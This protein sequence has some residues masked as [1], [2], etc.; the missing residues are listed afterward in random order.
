M[1]GVPIT[2]A[3]KQLRQRVLPGGGFGIHQDGEFR[4]DATAWGIIALNALEPEEGVIKA[5]RQRLAG[6]QLGDG[7]VPI[8][9]EHKEAIWPTTLAILAWQGALAFKAAQEKAAAYLLA[10]SGL[11]WKKEAGSVAS[12]DPS[13][14]GWSWRTDTFSWCEPTAMAMMALEI[15]GYGSHPRLEEAQRLLLDR[16]IPGGG[17]NYGN[18][19]VFGS[20][21]HPMP[22]AT[23]MVLNALSRK[24]P[25]EAVQKSLVY[26]ENHFASLRTP[27]S[28]GWALL[29]LGAWGARPTTAASAIEVC[30]DRQARFGGYDTSSLALILVA[31]R[32]TGGLVSL[33]RA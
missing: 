5:A 15:A 26:L 16:Q 4:P 3:L 14:L 30:L 6:A 9:P 23:G 24:V 22:E 28:L 21:L 10:I 13:L 17:W 12:H 20:V 33:Y 29:G 32:A 1:T 27:R 2:E 11:H 8:S 25:R 31:S 18:T 7:R 19:S